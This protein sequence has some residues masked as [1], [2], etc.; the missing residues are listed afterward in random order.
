MACPGTVHPQKSPSKVTLKSQPH[1]LKKE[2]H[3]EVREHEAGV[4]EDVTVAM[5]NKHAVHADLTQTTDREHAQWGA[6]PWRR[7]WKLL[8]VLRLQR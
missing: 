3:R 1:K 2:A 6:L 8:D 7:P 4:D 5:P